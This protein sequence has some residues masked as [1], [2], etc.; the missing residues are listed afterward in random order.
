MKPPLRYKLVFVVIWLKEGHSEASDRVHISNNIKLDN[1][2]VHA[3]AISADYLLIY[4]P[5]T[6]KRFFVLLT[7]KLYFEEL[8]KQTLLGHFWLTFEFFLLW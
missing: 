7:T 5:Q 3:Q 6:W 8:K 4:S 1:S 2:V